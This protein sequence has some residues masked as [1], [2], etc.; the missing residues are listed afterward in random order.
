MGSPM[1]N[2]CL[3][4]SLYA[5]LCGAAPVSD[6][7]EVSSTPV[8]AYRGHTA[9]LPCWLNPPQNAEG[10]EVRWYR[11]DHFDSPIMFYRGRKFEDTSK[12]ASYVGRVSFDLKD[13]A[14]GGLTAGDVSL[15]LKNV[16]IED[17]GDYTCYIS[18]DQS[19]DRASVRLIVTEMGTTPLLSV[20]W[21]ED[22]MANVSCE[23]KGWYPKPSLSW[24]DKEQVLTSK[25]LTYSKDSSGLLS[26]H[27]WLLISGSTEVS[28]SVVVSNEEAKEARLR[29][30]KLPQPGSGSSV[31][32]WVAFA[33]LLTAMLVLLG[34]LYFRKRGKK[35]KSG[36]DHSE[37]NRNLLPKEMV[38]PTKLSA[39]REYYVNVTL[40]KVEN[41][42]LMIR[43]DRKVRDVCVDFPD[44]Q[45]ATNL[46][47]KGTP[48][49]SSGQH[50][51]EVSL[52]SPKLGL[53]QSW[54]VGVTCA[55]DISKM[56]D[57][58]PT[59][60]NGFWILSSSPDMAD[61]FQFSTDPQVLLP[62]YSRPQTVGVYLNYDSGELSFY[63]VENEHLI[64][65]L[66]AT[67]RGEVFP[68][69]NPGIGDKAPMEILHRKEQ[70]QANNMENA[71]D[72]TA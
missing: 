7:L 10:L 19:Y 47:V 30:A 24:L 18:S 27:S 16:T 46:T 1:V 56:S 25:S 72:S 40:D 70:G 66:K 67:F 29:L 13:A 68:V 3:M 21:K 53:K 41:A 20:V 49:F 9:T 15:K 54:W 34:V 12:E 45:Q 64:G 65:T 4:V 58:P 33:L 17:A 32:G 36:S 59:T 55:A 28:C 69:F 44:G 35:A 5:S 51:W 43:D 23:S 6:S 31:G 63:N 71:V 62:V 50:Y 14:S 61:S 38:Q 52:G 22:N 8:S 60:S 2:L 26:V 11:G 42:Y 48:G 57:F 39:A 37:E